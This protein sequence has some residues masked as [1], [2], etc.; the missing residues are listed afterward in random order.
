M[1]VLTRKIGQQIFVGDNIIIKVLET[2]DKDC[3]LGITAPNSTI[4]LREEL[5]HKLNTY[6][7]TFVR[8]KLNGR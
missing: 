1:L 7:K 5:Y 6:N 2:N 4:I 3:K 8:G